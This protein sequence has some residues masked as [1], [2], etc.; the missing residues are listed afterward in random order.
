MEAK[1]QPMIALDNVRFSYPVGNRKESGNGLYERFSLS[2]EA[3][4]ILAVMGDSGSGKSTLGRLIAGIIQP[5]EG[6]VV[7][8]N[9]LARPADVVYIDQHPMNSVFPWQTV[10]ENL[11]YPLG[12]LGWNSAEIDKR[13]V[14]LHTVFHLGDLLDSYP[15]Q[16][17]GGEL[18]RLALARSLSWQPKMA[19]LDESFSALDQ[20]LREEI[21]AAVRE[22]ARHDQ[23]TVVLITHNLTDALALGTRC[24]VI[25]RHPVAVIVDLDIGG[26]ATSADT[27][28]GHD[29]A[30]TKLMEVIRDGYI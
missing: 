7:R 24:V 26:Q 14:Y 6:R 2:V 5:S 8:A 15:A 23:L 19:I 1:P 10:R 17:S 21:I 12:K 16:L 30:R 27:G 28:T 18:Q 11:R 25:G 22:L 20:R 13:A 29:V 3:G 9:D 4:S